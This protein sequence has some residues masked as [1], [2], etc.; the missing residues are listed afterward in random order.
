MK[1]IAFTLS[2]TDRSVVEETIERHCGI[3]GWT[4]HAVNARSNHVHV[5]VTA[6]GCKPEVVRNQFKAW[7]TRNLKSSNLGRERFW[8]EGASCRWINLDDDLES[9]ILYTTDA[10]EL[11]RSDGIQARRASE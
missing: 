10:Q 2:A 11:K 7:C 6:L 9:A 4:L 3:R 8:T 5:V 1:E